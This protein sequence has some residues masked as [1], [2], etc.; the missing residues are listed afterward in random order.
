MSEDLPPSLDV[1][2]LPSLEIP[3]SE[4]ESSSVHEIVDSPML[5]DIPTSSQP[6]GKKKKKN[7]AGIIPKESNPEISVTNSLSSTPKR[8]STSQ[9]S[10][11]IPTFTPIGS[12][13][14]DL[15]DISSPMPNVVGSTSN[16][17][18]GMGRKKGSILFRKSSMRG[19]R[20]KDILSSN[21]NEVYATQQLKV[22]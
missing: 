20:W 17:S 13:D 22:I 2:T 14:H 19:T 21:I 10:V 7:L 16:S 18:H 8:S 4:S 3:D 6:T 9:S 11:V 12:V 5:E 1:P 15:K